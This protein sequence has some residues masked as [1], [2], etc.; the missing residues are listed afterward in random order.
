MIR[1]GALLAFV[2]VAWPA[3]AQSEAEAGRMRLYIQQ[4]E[5][6]VRQLTGENE[7][8]VHELS[9]LRAQPG[10][11]A[12]VGAVTISPAAPVGG[13]GQLEPEPA[14]GQPSSDFL[15][16]SI[17]ADDP[18]IAPD[19]DPHAA[20]P[21]LEPGG[22][23]DL[24]VLASGVPAG[25]AAPANAAGVPAPSLDGQVAALPAAASAMSGSP[26]DQYDLA[27]GYILTADYD[28]AELRFGE[29]LAANP[30]DPQA[31]DA[32]FWLGESH[33]QQGEFRE[34]ANSF[35]TVYKQAGQSPKAPDS[36]LKLGMSLAALG[37]KP[38][39]CATLSE[40]AKRYPQADPA[41]LSRVDDAAGQAGC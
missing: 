33:F 25:S 5:D 32:R 15:A 31:T 26:R 36:L 23:I 37:E 1:V 34:A 14:A 40:V 29:W 12:Q 8:L 16:N 4:L 11:P 21:Q 27:Y 18:L 20:E 41:L 3:A 17:A 6:R 28:L 9:L 24:S 38:A 35:L 22:P 10:A 39:A 7:Q 19:G 13:A 2:L 30:A